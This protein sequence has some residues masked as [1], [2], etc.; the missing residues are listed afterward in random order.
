MLLDMTDN[1]CCSMQVEGPLELPMPI[2]SEQKDHLGG[3][4]SK[5]AATQMSQANDESQAAG[6]NDPAI[7]QSPVSHLQQQAILLAAKAA[8]DRQSVELQM[9]VM[10]LESEKT[11]L[12]TQ[13][14]AAQRCMQI[15]ESAACVADADT[16]DIAMSNQTSHQVAEVYLAATAWSRMLSACICMPASPKQRMLKHLP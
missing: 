12:S 11:E 9:R 8:S 3:E 16:V 15:T 13:L 4:A 1:S 10:M 7:G 6:G 2:S 5:P 14:C